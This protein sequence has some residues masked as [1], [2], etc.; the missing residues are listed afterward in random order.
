MPTRHSDLIGGSTAARVVNC[1]GSARLI[2]ALPASVDT[3]S[4]YA[5]EGTAMHEVIGAL[6]VGKMR[7][8]AIVPG[9]TTVMA[10]G[11]PI[12]ITQTL[13]DDCVVPAF[14]LWESLM[15][16]AENYAVEV[17]APFPGLGGA[18]G[19]CDLGIRHKVGNR[20]TILDWKFG[21]GVGVQA[22]Y[23]D[24]DDD[25]YERIAEQLLFYA[26]CLRGQKPQWFPPG[27]AIDLIIF[28]PRAQNPDARLTRATVANEDLDAFIKDVFHA[29]AE[30]KDAKARMLIGP[31]CRFAP[32]RVACPLHAAPL[33]DLT[34]I[35]EQPPAQ[36]FKLHADVLA[37]VLDMA[38]TVEQVIAEARRQALVRLQ[39]G[40]EIPGWRLGQARTQRRWGPPEHALLK[41]LRKLYR[42]RKAQ[43]Y[44]VKFKSPAQ[45]EKLLPAKTKVPEE[46]AA[47]PLGA[48]TLVRADDPR[49]SPQPLETLQA[50]LVQSAALT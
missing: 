30:A 17:E 15:P 43:C 38:D 3:G 33:L 34:A 8:S 46:L 7:L 11:Q 42:L 19:T 48:A 6:I 18:F 29:I 16:D 20:T 35:G 5:T 25:D 32:C 12:V 1:P 39:E 31:W 22:V 40:G 9:E 37:R 28:Q 24:P 47:A 26:V 14:Q 45:I 49:P 10:D 21:V 27:V 36:P 50:L 44:E 13:F 2:A 23:P 4:D 41:S